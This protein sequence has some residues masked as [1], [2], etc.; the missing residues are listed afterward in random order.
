MQTKQDPRGA[1]L[2]MAL[3]IMLH[4]KLCLSVIIFL[5]CVYW[6]FLVCGG[7]A[8]VLVRRQQEVTT[9]AATCMPENKFSTFIFSQAVPSHFQ[10]FCTS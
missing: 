5:V 4:A 3:K 7:G 8:C 2:L 10:F 6:H 9:L 1:V